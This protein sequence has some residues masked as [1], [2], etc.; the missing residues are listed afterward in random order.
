[1]TP[2]ELPP[3]SAVAVPPA[4]YCGI[5]ATRHLPAAA[6]APEA[7]LPGIHAPVT[8]L[9]MVPSPS[10]L[11]HSSLHGGIDATSFS[12]IIGCHMVVYLVAPGSA[13][14]IVTSLPLTWYGLPPACQIMLVVKPASP[15]S[16]VMYCLGLALCS[17]RASST[18]S[19]Q[20]AGGA[21]MPALSKT[22]LL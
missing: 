1:M 7:R 3:F 16:P 15:V 11:N 13:K 8:R 19:A 9:A 12:V 17:L 20:V 10:A 18:Y 21:V 4:S 6:F 22:S 5:G 2:S 14:L